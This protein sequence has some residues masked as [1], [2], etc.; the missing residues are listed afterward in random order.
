MLCWK[1][2]WARKWVAY[3]HPSLRPAV[4]SLLR[5]TKVYVRIDLM[6]FIRCRSFVG[7]TEANVE[8]LEHTTT[9]S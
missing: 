1:P 5:L 2:Q 9:H 8:G 3:Q 6:T 7:I 4:V